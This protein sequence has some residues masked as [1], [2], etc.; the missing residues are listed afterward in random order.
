MAIN[1]SVGRS[2]S[3][4]SSW[5]ETSHKKYESYTSGTSD[6]KSE[7]YSHSGSSNSSSSYGGRRTTTQTSS[8][9]SR[10]RDRADRE[11]K[12]LHI[13][14][15]GESMDRLDDLTKMTDAP[16]TSALIRHALQVYELF[17]HSEQEGSQVCIRRENGDLEIIKLVI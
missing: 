17:V 4:G 6:S 16:S 12:R 2:F 5:G 7:T 10:V 3:E 14:L 15:S 11:E 13:R 8:G 1:T 9:Y